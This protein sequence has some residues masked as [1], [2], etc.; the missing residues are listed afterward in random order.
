MTTTRRLR[1]QVLDL[2]EDLTA[3]CI[4][5]AL[6]LYDLQEATDDLLMF[7][8]EI[9]DLAEETAEDFRQ[10]ASGNARVSCQ[11]CD[12][13]IYV[14]R[15]QPG[16]Y[17]C[18][19]CRPTGNAAIIGEPE[20]IPNPTTTPCPCGDNGCSDTFG[21]ATAGQDRSDCCQYCGYYSCDVCGWT[22]PANPILC[23]HCGQPINGYSDCNCTPCGAE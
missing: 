14:E 20:R 4:D 19:F 23:R 6:T 2:H 16:P 5:T 17:T 3:T 1:E 9:E 22:D 10:A 15:T 18:F 21:K 7:A 8:T 12:G 11:W 13:Q